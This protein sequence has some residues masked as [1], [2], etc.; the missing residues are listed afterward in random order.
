MFTDDNRCESKYFR[1]FIAEYRQCAIKTNIFYEN[2][3]NMVFCLTTK[4]GWQDWLARL[5]LKI[6]L[7]TSLGN[8]QSCASQSCPPV[9][10]TNVH[11]F[12]YFQKQNYNL[13]NTTETNKAVKSR[14]VVRFASF[15]DVNSW[16]DSLTRLAGDNLGS[17]DWQHWQPWQA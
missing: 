8:S 1:E 12:K 11:S 6:F 4:I 7:N 2:T 14:K 5:A 16:Q 15:S 13:A 10:Q 17:Q 3:Y 9:Y